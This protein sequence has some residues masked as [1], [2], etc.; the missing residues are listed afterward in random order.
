MDQAQI[1]DALQRTRNFAEMAGWSADGMED[2][3]IA[4][5][6]CQAMAERLAN[7][8]IEDLERQRAEDYCGSIP[9]MMVVPNPYGPGY[10][11]QCADPNTE[12]IELEGRC[13]PR[14]YVQ[15]GP[16]IP[17]TQP[18]VSGQPPPSTSPGGG[19]CGGDGSSITLLCQEAPPSN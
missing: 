4:V 8:R 16:G 10:A 13:V 9:G 6:S 15:P 1:A 2:I 11:C 7:E 18:P 3:L 5:A 14:S 19:G 17:P 12:F